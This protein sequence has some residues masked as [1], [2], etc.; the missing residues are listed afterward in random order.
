MGRGRGGGL[1]HRSDAR[2]SLLPPNYTISRETDRGGGRQEPKDGATRVKRRKE[3]GNISALWMWR[4]GK[5]GRR[6]NYVRNVAGEETCRNSCRAKVS[7]RNPFVSN[8][9]SRSRRWKFNSDWCSLLRGMKCMCIYI[10]WCRIVFFHLSPQEGRQYLANEMSR[11]LGR[12]GARVRP[13]S[14]MKKKKKEEQEEE[15]EE[16]RMGRS[17]SLLSIIKPVV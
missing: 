10:Y 4:T 14:R 12:E 1:N 5:D 11:F 2:S 3:R 6:R 16:E 13:W 17:R 8:E 15:E 7:P 9:E